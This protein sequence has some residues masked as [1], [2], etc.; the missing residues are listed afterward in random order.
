MM[1][2]IVTIADTFDAMT[3]T[4]PY[5]KALSQQQAYDELLR[6]R[7][8]QFDP[9]LAEVFADAILR[10][11]FTK[12]VESTADTVVTPPKAEPQKAEA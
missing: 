6:F 12:H 9:E 10:G 7:G 4:R 8:I 3:S 11:E 5:R 1:G 2:R